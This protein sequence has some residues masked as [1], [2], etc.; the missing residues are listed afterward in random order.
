MTQSHTIRTLKL[1]DGTELIARVF[2][3]ASTFTFIKDPLVVRLM[4][5]EQGQAT[6]VFTLWLLTA[7]DGEPIEITSA[8]ILASAPPS[9]QFEAAYLTA[10]TGVEVAPRKNIIV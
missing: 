6:P 5:N 2:E 8:N 3:G 1:V 4:P 10:V 9:D 7:E